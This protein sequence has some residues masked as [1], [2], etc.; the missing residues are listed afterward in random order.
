MSNPALMATRYAGRPLLLKPDAAAELA[1]RVYALDDRAFSRPGRLQA[2]LRKVGLAGKGRPQSVAMEDDDGPFVPPV[3]LE[4]RLAYAPRWAGEPEAVGF[5]WTL[6]QGVALICCDTP[7]VDQGDEF[8]GVVFHGYD[9]LL[10]ALR[11]A[12][13]DPRVKGIHLRM[14]S[15]GGVVAG[16]LYEL[17]AWMRDNRAAAG[18]KPIW[19]YA[20]MACSA[21]YW[22]SAQADRVIAPAVG[23]V[24]SIGA[25]IVH[26][27]WSEA[28]AK[29]GVKVTAVEFPLGKT[30]GA[31]W[32][33][34]SPEAFADLTAEIQQVAGDFFA[35]VAAGRPQ[36]TA[37]LLA[38]LK[39]RVFLAKHDDP[40]RS[41]QAI[42][43]VDAIMSEEAAFAALCQAVNGTTSPAA[44]PHSAANL[45]VNLNRSHVTAAMTAA[46]LSATQ[47]L[48]VAA[49]LPEE[50]D[51]G[52]ET[53][54]GTDTNTETV[55]GGGGEDSISGE[56]GADSL[57][58]G[59]GA[60]AI[61][62]DGATVLAIM[63]LP[64]AKGREKLARGL[65]GTAGMTAA[66]AK[67]LL[68]A[69]P[70]A[71]ALSPT[72]PDV[73]ASGGAQPK[74]EFEE[75]KALGASLKALRGGKR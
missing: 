42:G 2:I 64:E 47:M 4:E 54:A 48:A 21:A 10:Q 28:Y 41:G 14:S 29:A 18:G 32:K 15:P 6:N 73:S 26:E 1:N 60:D 62:P 69:A 68:G 3:P 39:A 57:E 27:D 11:E 43:F 16:G 17:A 53:T 52:S 72:D 7:L 24:G 74:G 70:K 35:D 66:I 31:D 25:V 5:A 67:T 20:D 40:A 56:S 23:L 19:V 63:D 71:S 12:S 45:E 55:A 61:T 9:T 22:I 59:A 51:G 30:D 36:L 13:A 65:A 46:G 8:C 49:N 58:G 33:A 38:T 34:L 44:P 37:E 50:D 75:A